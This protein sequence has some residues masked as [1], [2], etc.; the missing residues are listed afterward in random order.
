M[1]KEENKTTD[2]QYQ[3]FVSGLPYES[4]DDDLKEFFSEHKD[5]IT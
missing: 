1:A 4:T 3:V 5:D 2:K